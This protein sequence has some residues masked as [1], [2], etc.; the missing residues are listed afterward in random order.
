MFENENNKSKILIV[1][2]TAEYG[3]TEK[4]ANFI[5]N[6]VGGDIIKINTAIPYSSEDLNYSLPI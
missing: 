4:L 5:Y 3:N 6:Q 2:F 1:Y